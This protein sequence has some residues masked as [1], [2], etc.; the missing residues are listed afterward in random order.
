MSTLTSP[1]VSTRADRPVY[2]VTGLRVLRS[3]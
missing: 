3:E 2:R 1:A